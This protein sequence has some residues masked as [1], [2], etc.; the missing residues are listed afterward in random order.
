[1]SDISSASFSLN[2]I[3]RLNK[4]RATGAMSVNYIAEN[5]PED[6]GADW[7]TRGAN[8]RL[9]NTVRLN[10][11]QVALYVSNPFGAFAASTTCSVTNN[12]ATSATGG[13]YIS[14]NDAS[15]SANS[16][17]WVRTNTDLV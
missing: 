4:A 13:S 14:M 3:Y 2:G 1:M 9:G 17:F 7:F 12:A 10:K 8:Q 16:Y 11:N 6:E 5:H 15:T